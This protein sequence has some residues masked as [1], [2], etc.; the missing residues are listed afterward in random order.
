MMNPI[1]ILLS[2]PGI[3]IFN[4]ADREFCADIRQV[5]KIL[6]VSEAELAS[7]DSVNLQY[8]CIND[9]K[10]PIIDMH[11]FFGL[12]KSKRTGDSRV[13][14][15]EVNN[16]IYGFIVEKIQEFMAI[17]RKFNVEDLST[18][19][20]KANLFLRAILDYDGRRIALPD[21][22]KIDKALHSLPE[23]R[24]EDQKANTL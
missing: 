14:F 7:G 15:V 20:Q 11:K 19:K 10:I 22:Q 12:K 21:F 8:I 5:Y 13:L 24:V 4:I 2:I 17:T 18:A 9:I 6:K 23:D 3:V 1:D 16:T